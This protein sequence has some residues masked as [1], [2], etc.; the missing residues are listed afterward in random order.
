M[1]LE[2]K[3]TL[4]DL[5]LILLVSLR[6][7]RLPIGRSHPC[8]RPVGRSLSVCLHYSLPVT[9][10]VSSACQPF[11][12]SAAGEMQWEQADEGDAGYTARRGLVG[13]GITTTPPPA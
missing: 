1:L 8:R 6:R 12:F 3:V 13:D 7:T 9:A 5:F 11:D 10:A 4:V 2:G